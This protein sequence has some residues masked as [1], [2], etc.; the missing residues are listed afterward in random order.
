MKFKHFLIF[1]VSA[2]AAISSGVA[3]ADEPMMSTNLRSIGFG[4]DLNNVQ[5][6]EEANINALLQVKPFT[7]SESVRY[8]GPANVTFYAVKPELEEYVEFSEDQLTQQPEAP[9][10]PEEPVPPEA[11]AT[12]ELNPEW[13]NTLLIWARSARN[14]YGVMAIDGDVLDFSLAHVRF[15]NLTPFRLGLI[16]KDHGQQLLQPFSNW[17]INAE[18]ARA[19][20]FHALLNVPDRD[21]E[22]ISNVVE[23][24]P[25]VRRTVFFTSFN[26]DDTGVAIASNQRP[27]LS[28]WIFTDSASSAPQ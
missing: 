8:H 27:S 2:S 5:A 7:V 24:R 11:I 4:V 19:I 21:D 3:I 16:T 22:V 1:A 15:V 13:S 12:V 25:H 10:P 18:D 20:Y 14:R 6:D 28:Y 23:M 26:V 17:T 9:S